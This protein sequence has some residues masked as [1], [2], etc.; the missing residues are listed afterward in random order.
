MD[1]IKRKYDSDDDAESVM[2]AS[3]SDMMQKVI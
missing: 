1:R 3:E 2:T